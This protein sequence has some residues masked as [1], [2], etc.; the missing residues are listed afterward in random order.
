MPNPTVITAIDLGTDKCTTLIAKLSPET[1]Q[2]KVVGVSAVPSRGMKKSQII[3]LEQAM[4]TVAES[5]DAAER[6]AGVEV[7]S[8]WVAISGG[9][10]HS[11]N[12]K[13][14]VAVA[15]PDQE[16]TQLDIERVIEAARAVSLPSDK[17]IIHVIPNTFKVD[18]QDGIK[19]PVGM[20]G[21]RLEADAHIITA[22]SVVLK[23]MHRVLENLGLT[24]NGF[25]FAGLAGAEVVLSETEKELGVCLVDIGAGTTSL[26]CYVDGSLVYSSSIP[27]GARHITQ[28]IAL[29]C[30]VS[31]D[32]AEQI[33]VKLSSESSLSMKPQN[34][35]SKHEFQAR[36]KKED[37]LRLADFTNGESSESLSRKVV[38]EG[39]IMP[40]ISELC[41]VIAQRL[42]SEHLLT[43]IPA[44][45]VITGGGAETI[46]L[47]PVAKQ[48]LKLPARIGLPTELDG[49]TLDIHK[50]A[51]A[52]SIGLLQYGK[53]HSADSE[54][55]GF[56]LAGLTALGGVGKAIQRATQWIKSL[57][58]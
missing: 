55:S 25:V 4:E 54:S 49:L 43:S 57:L 53:Q 36:R 14:V 37:E 22:M 15:A 24:S 27:I 46:G 21:V 7:R 17:E 29:G 10:I 23:N 51:F 42:E 44:G 9:H 16:I 32:I 5:L 50:P 45:L 31:I 38:V 3:D 26:C 20:A 52:T 6:M 8:C 34:G 35:E 28:D 58:P 2:L 18:S 12:S 33:K 13:G 47:I 39:I 41:S 48:Q 19:D 30:R 11:Q 40:R 1:K 56:S